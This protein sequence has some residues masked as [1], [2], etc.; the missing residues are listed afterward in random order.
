MSCRIDNDLVLP[1]LVLPCGDQEYSDK[2]KC[3]R[4]IPGDP[5]SSVCVPVIK[6]LSEQETGIV[7]LIEGLQN[8]TYIIKWNYF[9]DDESPEEL[10]HEIRIQNAAYTAGVAPKVIQF[11]QSNLSEEEYVYVIMTDLTAMG[12]ICVGNEYHE[13]ET[14]KF[15]KMPKRI[16]KATA[17]ALNTLH[18][19]GIAHNDFH[20]HNV[21][22]NPEEDRVMLID[23]GLSV[24]YPSRASALRHEDFDFE[25]DCPSYW[26]RDI[27]KEIIRLKREGL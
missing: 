6:V 23:Y 4:T 20:P 24:V 9:G 19:L 1:Q 14:G 5:D 11:Y 25:C 21:F 18:H 26:F 15:K 13:P 2:D 16:V 7:A 27:K 22:Y 3:F 12:Y 8:D 10:F 17:K